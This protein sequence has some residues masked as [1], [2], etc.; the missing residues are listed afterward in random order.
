MKESAQKI[1]GFHCTV[2]LKVCKTK[3]GLT[4]HVRAKHSDD[5]S[6]KSSLLVTSDEKL[7]EKINPLRLQVLVV[8]SADKLAQ[9]SCFPEDLRSVFSEFTFSHDES[10]EL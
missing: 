8:S 5:N 6:S 4:R 3:H 10:Y 2:C 9:N 1:E 7:M